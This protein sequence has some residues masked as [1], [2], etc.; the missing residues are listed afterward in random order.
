MTGSG[1]IVVSEGRNSHSSKAWLFCYSW[2]I[3]A[4]VLFRVVFIARTTNHTILLDQIKVGVVIWA[5]NTFSSV[6]IGSWLETISE[7]LRTFHLFFIIIQDLARTHSWINQIVWGSWISSIF[8]K[9]RNTFFQLWVILFTI[10]ARLTDFLISIKVWTFFTRN[11]T[12]AIEKWC[13]WRAV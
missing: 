9:E 13:F 1:C 6:V 10:F 12:N 2:I 3:V 4:L 8:F 5:T 7:R 11:T